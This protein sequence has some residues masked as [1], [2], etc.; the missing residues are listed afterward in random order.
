MKPI[1][2]IAF[3]FCCL[4][5]A[6]AAKEKEKAKSPELPADTAAVVNG[7]QIPEKIV[8]AFLQND[9]EAVG[10]YKDD[11]EGR[12]KLAELR[13]AIVQESIDRILIAQE[14]KKRGVAPSEAQIDEAEQKMMQYLGDDAHYEAFVRQNHFTRAEYRKYVL[15]SAAAG[16]A[17]KK[18]LT[19]DINIPTEEIRDY[20]SAH[21]SEPYFQ[22]PERVT[23]AHILFNTQ[24]NV[25]A[26]QIAQARKIAEGPEMERAISEETEKRRKLAEDV[27]AQAAGVADFSKLAEKYSDDGGT[28]N[29][30][31]S[32]STFAKGTHSLEL[33]E[34][35]FKL[36]TGE[37]GPVV[38]SEYGFHV[39]KAIDHKPAE[40]RTLEESTPE[41]QRRLFNGKAAR[42]MSDYLKELRAKAVITVRARS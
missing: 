6:G 24:R 7:E 16:E 20:F 26:A 38:H 28:K 25:L 30:G 19:K 34:A 11:E 23:G 40:P 12:K 9:Q 4:A 8:Q 1:R 41:I 17:L 33:D 29:S 31:G 32:L 27:R 2:V 36:K 35:F 39:I 15:T 5:S 21:K 42:L 14:A 37:V 22:W 10:S 18:E 3:F 13:E